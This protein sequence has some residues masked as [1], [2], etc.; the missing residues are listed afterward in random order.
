MCLL[1]ILH[2]DSAAGDLLEGPCLLAQVSASG[3]VHGVVCRKV[4]G[5]GATLVCVWR[6]S[7][8]GVGVAQLWCVLCVCVCVCGVTR[9]VYLIT[10]CLFHPCHT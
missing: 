10:M 4:V 1:H 9:A 2:H 3:V 7:A 8:A 6:R 5:V